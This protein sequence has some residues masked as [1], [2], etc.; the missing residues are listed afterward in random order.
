[1]ANFD[2]KKTIAQLEADT[3]T[4]RYKKYKKLR[5]FRPRVTAIS[6]ELNMFIGDI[7]ALTHCKEAEDVIAES[8]RKARKRKD[9]LKSDVDFDTQPAGKVLDKLQVHAEELRTE[10]QRMMNPRPGK[11]PAQVVQVTASQAEPHKKT[12]ATASRKKKIRRISS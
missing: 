3:A 1:M 6:S 11:P 4:W 5:N 10:L 12:Q 9:K 8:F 7:V 2:L